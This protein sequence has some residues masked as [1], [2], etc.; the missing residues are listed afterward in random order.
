MSSV[1]TAEFSLISLTQISPTLKMSRGEEPSRGHQISLNHRSQRQ[2]KKCIL[3][4]ENGWEEQI[5]KQLKIA[6]LSDLHIL[7]GAPHRYVF[8]SVSDAQGLIFSN[9]L[10]F[11]ITGIF[12]CTDPH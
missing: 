5:Y 3:D 4:K 2:K 6:Y 7:L 10:E 1:R 8:E 12:N 11:W 9:R